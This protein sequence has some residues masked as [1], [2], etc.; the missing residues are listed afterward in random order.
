MFRYRRVWRL[1]PVRAAVTKA[2][3]LS[4]PSELLAARITLVEQHD[5]MDRA[6]GHGFE[7]PL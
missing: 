5:V 6:G 1:A 3:I 4:P 2:Y 7:L